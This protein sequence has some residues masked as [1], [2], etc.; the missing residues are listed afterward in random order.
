MFKGF[1]PVMLRAFPANAVSFIDIYFPSFSDDV[2][3][4]VCVCMCVCVYVC[5]YACGCVC[6][7][8]SCFA[9]LTVFRLSSWVWK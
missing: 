3:M 9:V 7:H 5:V 1:V 2:C 8:V 4:H 6:V